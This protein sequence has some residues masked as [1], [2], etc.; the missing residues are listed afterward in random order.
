MKPEYKSKSLEMMAGA[1][2]RIERVLEMLEG[3][4]PADQKLAIQIMKELKLSIEKVNQLIE[5]S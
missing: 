3:S 4:R 5:L 2:S 1:N